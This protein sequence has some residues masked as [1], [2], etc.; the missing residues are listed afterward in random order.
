MRSPTTEHRTTRIWTGMVDGLPRIE[1]R[2]LEDYGGIVIAD[3]GAPW[4]Y[5]P[6][7]PFQFQM[8]HQDSNPERSTWLVRAT[9][10]EAVND[11][12]RWALPGRKGYGAGIVDESFRFVLG[13]MW[14]TDCG[15]H[16]VSA[17]DMG[18]AWFGCKAAFVELQRQQVCDDVS[19]AI[20]EGQA[21]ST[22]PGSGYV[23]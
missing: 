10:A 12:A 4:D 13:A 18:G 5:V 9:L 17:F 11:F 19:I 20:W 7:A 1:Q 16:G 23:E 3:T 21:M 15:S 22:A 14:F 8:F 6:V 2:R